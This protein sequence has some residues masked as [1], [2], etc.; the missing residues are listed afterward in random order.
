MY[1]NFDNQIKKKESYEI[2]F[3]YLDVNIYNQILDI[4]TYA[5]K[6]LN[7]GSILTNK[8]TFCSSD[9]LL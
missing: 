1:Q 9:R 3:H 2:S 5:H 8:P 4:F 7:Y 6:K